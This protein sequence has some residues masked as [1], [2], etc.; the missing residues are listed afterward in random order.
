MVFHLSFRT[1]IQHKPHMFTSIKLHA[2]LALRCGVDDSLVQHIF[3]EIHEFA[4]N[5]FKSRV[6]TRIIRS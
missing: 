5:V 4:V 3:E 2:L 6:R 1:T